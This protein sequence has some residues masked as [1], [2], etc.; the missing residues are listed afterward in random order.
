MRN[1]E[2]FGVLRLREGYP[3]LVTLRSAEEV[4]ELEVRIPAGREI[5]PRE[6]AMAEQLVAA[7]IDTF[8]PRQYRNKFRQRVM[9][10]IEAKAAGKVIPLRQV[11]SPRVT[12]DLATAL[13]A[14]LRA[15][16]ERAHG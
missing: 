1:K 6:L 2:Y 12:G 15:A 3:L 10:F 9:E 13:E 5:A 7:M 8:D 16:R 11:A 4:V 14:S